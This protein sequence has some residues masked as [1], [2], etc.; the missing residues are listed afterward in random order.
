MREQFVNKSWQEQKKEEHPKTEQLQT[1]KVH[2]GIKCDFYR[3]TPSG[4]LKM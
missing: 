2:D 4:L 1:I 3:V